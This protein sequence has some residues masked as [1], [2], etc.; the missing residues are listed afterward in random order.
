[1]ICLN[2]NYMHI[3]EMWTFQT[4]KR[5]DLSMKSSTEYLS[6]TNSDLRNDKCTI[7]IGRC[8]MFK[9]I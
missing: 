3:S 2:S 4:Y 6:K 5:H 8:L 7:R 1:M 9:P